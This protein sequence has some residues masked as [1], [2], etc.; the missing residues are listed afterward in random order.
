MDYEKK[1]NEALEKARRL[2][3]DK[4]LSNEAIEE[5]FPELRESEDEKVKERA[6]A[7]LKQQRDY[8]SYDGP[9]NKFPPSTKRKDLV[10]AIDAALACL[11]KQKNLDKMIVVSPEVWDG[12]IND[13]Y[14]NGK[15][16]SEKQ[17]E[18]KPLST[19]E[20]E[21]NSLAFLE[22]MGYTCIPP[23]KEHQN[24]SDAPK[25]ALGG[26]LNSPLDK[27]K[28]LDDIAQDYVEAVK[29]Y[30]P[31]P[32]WDLMQ[33]AVCYGYHLAEQ[34]KQKPWKVGANAYFTPEQKSVD[35]SEMMV[36]KEPYIAP[37]PTPMV[38]D[39]QKPII[40]SDKFEVALEEFL[41]NARDKSEKTFAED[42]KEYAD[43]LREIVI[44]EKKEQ[45]HP[46]G[47]F[48]C[49]EYKKGYEEGRRNGFTA[50]YNK[51]MKEVE[52]KEQKPVDFPTTDEEV[53]E[54]LET[55]SKV[56]VPEKYKTPDFVFSKQ[57]YKSYPIISKDTTSVKP[58]EWSEED[59][60]MRDN[61]LRLLSC[62]VGTSECDS[63]P[64]L[65]TSY[66]AYQKE[67][68]WLKSLRPVSKESLQPHWKPSEE[69]MEALKKVACNLVGT[70]TETDVYLIQ[71]FEQLKKL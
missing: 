52:Q 1:Y 45:K 16:D 2:N 56:E 20:T 6:I 48:T 10:E 55:H 14:E 59:E 40:L 60:A 62:F 53:N 9:V 28:N 34:E 22:Q 57:E 64:S 67:I 50:G 11:E 33:T 21:L 29:E 12:A 46:N 23:K 19:E 71:L 41:M 31:E 69:Q 54:F 49:D 63:N 5:I 7:I 32:T 13:A 4:M 43:R 36:H 8:W 18:Q 68:S 15:K 25:N 37:V 51:A 38:A 35:L 44:N 30:N 17:K 47:C 39:E 26:A 42:V 65:S 58:A 70:G 66:P 24:N 27:D 3:V 61:I